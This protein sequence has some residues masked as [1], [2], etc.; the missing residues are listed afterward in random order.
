MI[1]MLG[2][3]SD[4]VYKV[5]RDNDFEDNKTIA[6]GIFDCKERTWSIYADNPKKTEP[7]ITIPLTVKQFN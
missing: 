4:S 3:E 5:F 1:E 6:V 7:I 2:D